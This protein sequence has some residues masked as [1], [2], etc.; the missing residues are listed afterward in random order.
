ML[1]N[2]YAFIFAFLPFVFAIHYVLRRAGLDRFAIAFLA[3][4]SL[5]FYAWWNPIYVF[6]I[7]GLI[8][9]NYAAVQALLAAPSHVKSWLLA[10]GVAANLC[11]LGYFKYSNFFVDNINALLGIEFYLGE[12]VL[13]LGISFFTFQKIAL[14][15]D[16]YEGKIRSLN[17]LDYALFVLFFPQLIAGPIVH[18]SEAMPQFQ[19]R[20]PVQASAIAMGL[21]IFARGLAKKVLLAD[22]LAGYATPQ[23][24]AAA[25]G[26]PLSFLAAWG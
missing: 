5:G 8:V 2:S 14:L 21:T 1:F 9:G 22:S 20:G 18:H 25:T 15:A 17:F 16:A 12:V 4:A 19:T 7:G 11:V 26:A 23:F 6:L 24:D 13:P 3:I 10:L